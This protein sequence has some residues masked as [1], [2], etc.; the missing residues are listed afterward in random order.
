MTGE[1]PGPAMLAVLRAGDRNRMRIPMAP[2]D[3]PR[4]DT[5]SRSSAKVKRHFREKARR[6][7]LLRQRPPGMKERLL[8]GC[9][10][11]GIVGAIAFIVALTWSCLTRP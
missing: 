3:P 5:P 6:Q 2:K 8:S 10:A 11:F 1:S 9:M 4:K 7:K